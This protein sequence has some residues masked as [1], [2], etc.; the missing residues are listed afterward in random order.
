M[1]L[2]PGTGSPDTS[3]TESLNT[4]WQNM[5][6]EK[7]QELNSI[8]RFGE[9]LTVTVLGKLMGSETKRDI[10]SIVRK[11]VAF[12]K[13]TSLRVG[14][15][16]LDSVDTVS[17]VFNINDASF[18]ECLLRDVSGRFQRIDRLTESCREKRVR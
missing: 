13:E 6:K 2:R 17:N 5:L 14:S 12:R 11:D 4:L 7:T 18:V 3:I 16:I 9:C 10:L 1:E 8:N 15:D